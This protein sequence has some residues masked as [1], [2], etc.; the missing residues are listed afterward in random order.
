MHDVA[1]TKM[2]VPLGYVIKTPHGTVKIV[3]KEPVA[4]ALQINIGGKQFLQNGGKLL[5]GYTSQPTWQSSSKVTAMKPSNLPFS[6][7]SNV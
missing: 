3:M 1:T 4:F 6:Y 5:P 7:E 2:C